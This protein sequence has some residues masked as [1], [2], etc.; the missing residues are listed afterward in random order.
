MQG[1]ETRRTHGQHGVTKGAR[2]RR[3]SLGGSGSR[4]ESTGRARGAQAGLGEGGREVVY[5]QGVTDGVCAGKAP[6][7]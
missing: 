2:V 4:L 5:Q 3:C 6:G 1:G 7:D